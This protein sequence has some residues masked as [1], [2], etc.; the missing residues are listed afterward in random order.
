MIGGVKVSK[1]LIDEVSGLSLENKKK[2]WVVFFFSGII[3]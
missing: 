3:V 1:V 2:E